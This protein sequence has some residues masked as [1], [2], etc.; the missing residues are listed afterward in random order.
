MR[1]DVFSKN[2]S[3]RYIREEEKP[4]DFFSR[5]ISK[6][7]SISTVEMGFPSPIR[8]RF[9]RERVSSK[10]ETCIDIIIFSYMLSEYENIFFMQFCETEKLS[11]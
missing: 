8:E 2:T 10:Q 1:I 5:R 4:R 11:I 3:S 9:Y 7:N 6:S